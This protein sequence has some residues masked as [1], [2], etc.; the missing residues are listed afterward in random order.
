MGIRSTEDL[1]IKKNTFWEEH[2]LLGGAITILKHMSSSMGFGLSHIL[3]KIT[4]GRNHQLAIDWDFY[5]PII[6]SN[7][8]I[9]RQ[10]GPVVFSQRF[11]RASV[12]NAADLSAEAALWHPAAWEDD[13]MIQWNLNILWDKPN[14]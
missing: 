2:D 6:S 10:P 7:T 3:W 11:H 12:W 4:N 5:Y 9:T 1:G 8:H 14:G 13:R